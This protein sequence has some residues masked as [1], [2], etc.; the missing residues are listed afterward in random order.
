MWLFGNA[1]KKGYYKP[2][3]LHIED[4]M[5][6]LENLRLNIDKEARRISQLSKKKKDVI[7]DILNKE[8][9]SIRLN[10]CKNCMMNI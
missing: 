10:Y 2:Q 5:K 4:P 9:D 7:F 8:F 3:A 1:K 6:Y